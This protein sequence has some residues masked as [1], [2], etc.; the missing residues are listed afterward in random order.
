MTSCRPSWP[1]VL[2]AWV[3]RPGNGYQATGQIAMTTVSS[4]FSAHKSLLYKAVRPMQNT[5]MTGRLV[6]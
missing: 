5:I 2:V 3:L 6:M 1:T 4:D